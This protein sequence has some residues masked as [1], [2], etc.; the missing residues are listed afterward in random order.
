MDINKNKPQNLLPQRL[1]ESQ[2][3]GTEKEKITKIRKK[4]T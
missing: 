3:E 4:W 2:E 1:E